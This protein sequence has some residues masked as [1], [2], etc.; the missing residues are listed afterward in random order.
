MRA[1]GAVANVR[2]KK[3]RVVHERSLS[4]VTNL[5]LFPSVLV[6]TRPEVDLTSA[7][8][9]SSASSK[10]TTSAATPPASA[11]TPA[12]LPSS[13]VAAPAGGQEGGCLVDGVVVGAAV[14][15]EAGEEGEGRIAR[16]SGYGWCRPGTA[17]E[18]LDVLKESTDAWGR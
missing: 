8:G 5:S 2:S 9:G 12:Q 10:A 15:D 4:S 16:S 1:E 13:K 6:R 3:E 11:V 7:G 18:M 14:L 17:E